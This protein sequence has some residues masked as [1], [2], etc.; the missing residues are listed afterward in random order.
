MKTTDRSILVGLLILGL[1]AC[2]WFMLLAPK[3][4]RASELDAQAADLQAQV[5]Q[6]EQLADTA[7]SSQQEYGRNYQ[8]LIVLGKAAPAD[9]DTPSLLAQLTELSEKSKTKFE[10]LQLSGDAPEIPAP[11]AQTTTDQNAEAGVPTAGSAEAAPAGPSAAT[12]ASAAVLPLGATVGPAGLGVMPYN[13]RFSG[14]FFQVADLLAGLDSLVG[15]DEKGTRVDGR[16]VTVNGFTIA[17][18]EP[19][20]TNLNVDLSI[21][22]YVLPDSQGLTAGATPAAPSA[23]VP[24]ASSVPTSTATTP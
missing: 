2:F 1:L 24:P 15:S 4:E 6:Q 7:A 12:E 21:T 3:R 8:S 20:A 11:A 14:D 5:A 18:P 9:G 19:G 22:A 23:D 13:V 16:L 17:P 10:S